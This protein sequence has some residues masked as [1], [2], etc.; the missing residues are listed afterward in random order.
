VDALD[1]EADVRVEGQIVEEN[2]ADVGALVVEVSASPDAS[3]TE[4]TLPSAAAA[5]SSSVPAAEV[6]GVSRPP[7]ASSPCLHHFR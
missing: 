3:M 2:P 4:A 6:E 5:P 7:F 1:V